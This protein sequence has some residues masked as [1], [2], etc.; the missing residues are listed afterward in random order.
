M[1]PRGDTTLC[2]L[3]GYFFDATRH[4][5]V[6]TRS[7]AHC[8]RIWRGCVDPITS[9]KRG[10]ELGWLGFH[11]AAKERVKTEPPVHHHEIF[12]LSQTLRIPD[13]MGDIGSGDV[14]DMSFRRGPLKFE[15]PDE[16]LSA[17][18]VVFRP[19]PA[20]GIEQRPGWKSLTGGFWA[21]QLH[22]VQILLWLLAELRRLS[23]HLQM[24]HPVRL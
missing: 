6:G 5:E 24:S 2:G 3:I 16:Q 4:G 10:V 14:V 15:V 8:H 19:A 22:R 23:G 18:L 17:F 20:A 13:S 11:V 21:C 9:P 12:F 1:N 7:F